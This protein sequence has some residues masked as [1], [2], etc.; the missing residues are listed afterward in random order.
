VRGVTSIK[1]KHGEKLLKLF[2]EHNIHPLIG[3]IFE[4]EQVKDAFR[5]S[6]ERALVGKVVV[7]V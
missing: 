2:E 6:M 7:K 4:W 5:K 1:K 3:Q